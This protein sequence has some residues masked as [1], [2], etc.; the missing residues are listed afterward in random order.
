MLYCIKKLYCCNVPD[1][2]K[3]EKKNKLLFVS[4]EDK[5]RFAT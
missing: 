3:Y 5:R 4:I 2:G 1:N